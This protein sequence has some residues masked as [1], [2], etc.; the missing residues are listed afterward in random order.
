MKFARGTREEMLQLRD[1]DSTLHRYPM[2]PTLRRWDV[3]RR[4]S[5]Y[6]YPVDVE[7]INRCGE[8]SSEAR[9]AIQTAIL[10]VGEDEWCEGD[11]VVE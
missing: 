8:Y 10:S 7:T 9:V 6:L 3:I 4:G 5:G 1:E 11:E 2:G